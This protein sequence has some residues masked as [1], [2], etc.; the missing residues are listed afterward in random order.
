MD[1]RYVAYRSFATNLLPDDTNGVPDIFLC[2]QLTGETTLVSVSQLGNRSA[3]GRSLHP[4]AFSGDG[5]MRLFS[6]Q[7]RIWGRM[8]FIKG[9]MSLHYCCAPIRCLA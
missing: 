8:I 3:N 7:L 9:G 6:S 2:D 5:L 1:G 4:A